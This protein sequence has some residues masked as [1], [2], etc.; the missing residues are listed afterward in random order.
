VLTTGTI[1]SHATRFSLEELRK[2]YIEDEG[3]T[4]CSIKMEF[5]KNEFSGGYDD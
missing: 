1:A 2:C 5:L 3:G 4:T